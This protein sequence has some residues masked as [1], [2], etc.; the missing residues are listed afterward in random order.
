MENINAEQIIKALEH[1]ANSGQCLGCRYD[2]GTGFT[3]EGCMACHMR[4]ALALIISQEQR[5]KELSGE[6]N[7]VFEIGA[8]NLISLEEAY[9]KLEAENLKLTEENERLQELL[10]KESTG[11]YNLATQIMDLLDDVSHV[12]SDTVLKTLQDVSLLFS[13]H[14]GTYTDDAVVKIIEVFELLNKIKKSILED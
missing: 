1:C 12:K 6:K 13:M 14:F 11:Q 3:K 4:D 8:A 2:K 5:I 7:K 9:L 10:D